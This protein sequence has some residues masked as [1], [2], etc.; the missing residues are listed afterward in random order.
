MDTDSFN[1]IYEGLSLFEKRV[2][3]M[4]SVIYESPSIKQLEKCLSA[5]KVKTIDG[6]DCNIQDIRVALQ[7]LENLHLIRENRESMYDGYYQCNDPVKNMATL[8]AVQDGVMKKMAATVQKAIPVYM[9][10]RDRVVRDIRI[11]FYTRD[12]EQ[13]MNKYRLGLSLYQGYFYNTRIF[14][15]IC[16][17][18]FDISWFKSLPIL[19]QATALDEIIEDAVIALEPLDK[20]LEVLSQY[21]D[22]PAG[23]AK[24]EAKGDDYHHVRFLL[25]TVFIFQGKL[26]EASE[27]VDRDGGD[28]YAHCVRGALQ[29]LKGN[30]DKSIEEYEAGLKLFQ[31]ATKKRN[32]FFSGILGLFFFIAK[33]QKGDTEFIYKYAEIIDKMPYYKYRISLKM[34]VSVCSSLDGGRLE[35]KSLTLLIRKSNSKDY[36]AEMLY[37]FAMYYIDSRIPLENR[38]E[39]YESYRRASSNGY[40][41]LAMD[42]ANLLSIV[43]PDKSELIGP[44][45]TD[46]VQ[47]TRQQ[48]G[49]TGLMSLLSL[50]TEP[51]ERSLNAIIGLFQADRTPDAL[52]RRFRLIWQL[53]IDVLKNSCIIEPKEQRLLKSGMWSAGKNV[54][55]KRLYDIKSEKELYFTPQDVQICSTLGIDKNYSGMYYKFDTQKALI[56]M[57]DHPMLFTKDSTTEKV[58][59]K[60]GVPELIVDKS[61]NG[62][63][64]KISPFRDDSDVVIV[65]EATNK[66]K[67]VE[68]KQEHKKLY[69]LIGSKGL[70]V[71]REARDK[72]LQAAGNLSSIVQV[73]SSMDM[74]VENAQVIP[75]DARPHI[76]LLPHR[77]GLKVE[78]TSRPFGEAGPYLKPGVG[79]INLLMEIAGKPCQTHRDFEQERKNASEV[80]NASEVLSETE[81]S[82]W[83]WIVDDPQRCLQLLVELRE[84]GDSTVLEWPEGQRYSVTKEISF[85]SLRLA[86]R[87]QTDWFSV[88][89]EITVDGSTVMEL[90]Q[91]LELLDDTEGRFVK[92]DEGRYMLLSRQLKKHLEDMKA[93]AHG[94]SKD[95]RMHPL[96]A[97]T[98]QDFF[99]DV[100]ALDVDSGWREYIKKVADIEDLNPVVPSTLQ[101]E[102]RD[103]QVEGFKW[104]S[105]L[106]HWGVGACL[107]DDMGLGKTL[108]ALAVIIERAGEGAS[109]VVVPTSVQSNWQREAERFAPTLNVVIFGGKDRKQILEGLMPNDLVLC[110]YG[111]LQSEIELLAEVNWQTIVLDE[112]QAIK[113]FA[114]KRSQAAMKLKGGFKIITTGTPIENHLG[115]LWNLFNFINPGLLGSLQ[116]FNNRFAVPIEKYNNREAKKRL[117]RLVQPFILRRTKSQ[118]L[119]ELPSRTEIVLEVEMSEKEAAFY[120]ALRQRAIERL[121]MAEGESGQKLISI[122]AELMKL[123]RACCNPRLVNQDVDIPSSKLSLFAEVLEELLDNKHKVLVFSQFVGHLNII[124]QYLDSKSVSYQYLDGSTPIK[125]RTKAVEDFQA[126]K[127]DVFLISIKAGGFGLNLTAADYVIHMDPWWNPAVEDQA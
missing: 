106:A 28:F 39:L 81:Q 61:K 15:Q 30:T 126:G 51:W 40:P 53:N 52:Q 111:L 19:L 48:T 86:L 84:L 14:N 17:M 41:I 66:Y 4:I 24:G 95:V 38:S 97:L 56:A 63:L 54:A 42:M 107:A 103:Y 3:Q 25:A 35:T 6:Y 116:R 10:N 60:R 72:V 57:I 100:R 119:E 1:G 108:E 115:E 70:H 47:Q 122:L 127:G 82:D 46:F 7:R 27:V 68:I 26:T 74:S 58:E 92:L 121:E 22:S 96:A 93:Y 75:S 120:E 124:R 50:K 55:L 73:H 78:M 45:L 12:V 44:E 33:L 8:K 21:K 2:L 117:K 114:T 16:N 37:N 98:L 31:K 94:Q 89:G 125:D 69:S 105:R 49:A 34:I 18:P 32:T 9:M 62:Y 29:F 71:P 91:V 101:V 123:R 112:A 87:R 67:I 23:D 104:L 64:L 85:D 102:L 65:K 88:S 11:G 79:G 5:G 59:L 77:E 20:F 90:K 118:V 99:D 113:N 110:T 13:A 43:V 36:I 109:L 76:R 83:D 80:I